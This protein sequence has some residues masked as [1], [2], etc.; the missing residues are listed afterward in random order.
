MNLPG[1]R[2]Y[3]DLLEESWR[4]LERECRRERQIKEA[5]AARRAARLSRLATLAA[6]LRHAPQPDMCPPIVEAC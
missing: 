5:R 6:R 1:V 2:L 4:E 3:P